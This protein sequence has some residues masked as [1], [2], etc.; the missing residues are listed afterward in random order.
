M[1]NVDS[2]GSAGNGIVIQVLGEMSNDGNPNRKFAQTFFLA[3]QPNG[4]YVLNDMFR[5]L[6]D[7]DDIEEGDYEYSAP[8]AAEPEV[9][10]AV[11]EI[12]EQVAEAIEDITVKET[13]TVEVDM[14]DG[15]VTKVEETRTVEPEEV[16]EAVAEEI[17]EAAAVEEAVE[18]TAEAVAEAIEEATAAAEPEAVEPVEET[19]PEPTPEP[20]A[21]VEKPVETPAVSAPKEAAPPAP[22]PAPVPARPKTWASLVATKPAAAAAAAAAAAPAATP[23]AAPAVSAPSQVAPASTAAPVAATA[24]TA[25]TPV[26]QA[27][28][29]A[30]S[31]WQ[32]A[33]KKGRSNV[34]QQTQ[35]AAY[36]KNV[37]DAV[38]QQALKDTL[39]KYGN[40]KHFEINKVKAS[41]SFLYIIDS[42]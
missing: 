19:K 21:P 29:A 23:T 26:T 35:T 4:Y 37:T 30:A 7:D 8:E 3:E 40:L 38:S 33:E 9:A 11:E 2:Q 16:A 42:Y 6:K 1:S 17:V 18:A 12:V 14:G 25:A 24:A 15:D 28:P 5:Y 13:H 31:Q 41:H 27:T 20:V 34:P 36:I 32:T 10:E 39:Q 22:A